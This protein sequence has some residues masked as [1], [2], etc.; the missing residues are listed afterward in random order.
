MSLTKTLALR[1][2]GFSTF[3]QQPTGEQDT[4]L[5]DLFDLF[6]LEDM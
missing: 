5:H 2:L 3:N 6:D 4:D 1:G